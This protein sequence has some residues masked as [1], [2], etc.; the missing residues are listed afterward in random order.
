VDSEFSHLRW[1]KCSKKDG[2]IEG[3]NYPLLSDKDHKIAK[4]YGVYI[5]VPCSLPE[6]Y[7]PP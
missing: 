6:P 4:D 2:G 3:C 1:V 5:E 7:R